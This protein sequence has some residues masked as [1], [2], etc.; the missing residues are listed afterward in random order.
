VLVM[1]FGGTSVGSGQRFRQVAEIVRKTLADGEVPIVVV[2]AMSGVTNALIEAAK[3]AE[4][5]QLDKALS[6]SLIVLDKHEELIAELFSDEKLRTQI[7][8]ELDPYFTQINILLQGIAYLGELSK[9]SL[10]A[11]SGFG[12]L[13]SSTIFAHYLKDLGE[14]AAWVDARKFMVTDESFGGATPDWPQIAA[15]AKT[16]FTPCLKERVIPVTQGYIGATTSGISTTLGRGGSDF[17]ASIIGVVLDA[18]EIQIWTDVDGMM[19]ADPRLVPDACVLSEVSFQEASELAYFGAKILH[20]LT[21]KPAVEK[22]IPVRILNTMRPESRGTLIT[23]SPKID[24]DYPHVRSI[25]AKKGLTAIFIH[26][27]GMLMTHGF[28]AKVFD[29]FARFETPIDLIATSEV[30]ISLTTDKLE[31]LDKIVRALEERGDEVKLMHD[32]AIVS[33]VGQHFRVMSG[34]ASKIFG[35]LENIN[36]IMISSG[37]SDVNVNFVLTNEDADKA[38]K[39]LHKNLFPQVAGSAH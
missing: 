37:A 23:D 22:K 30:S 35:A 33:V 4:R 14:K 16:V 3:L 31:S 34:I 1:K 15:K 24:S 2:S 25:A 28:L 7:T 39:Q 21:I 11:I 20:P 38:V 36:L 26:S 27:P 5:R 10:D 6:Q 32:V 19:T 17:S 12:E 18:S 9:R 13:L 8:K 29:I